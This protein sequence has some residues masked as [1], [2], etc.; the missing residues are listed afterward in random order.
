MELGATV[1]VPRDPRCPLCPVKRECGARARGIEKTLPVVAPK[2]KPTLERRAAAVL[3]RGDTV[4]LGRRRADGR[5]GGMWEPPSVV[6]TDRPSA[7][8]RLA[9]ALGIRL[10][11]LTPRGVVIHV[12]SHRRLEVD[13]FH[14]ALSARFR[15]PGVVLERAGDYE[16]FAIVSLDQL[17]ARGVTTLARKLL[18]AAAV[19]P[20]GP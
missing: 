6:S 15:A 2:K 8:A 3:T 7:P 13:V 14:G 12:L 18:A 20:G 16:A 10:P 17:A 19:R 4:L 11:T 1:C 5:F 9:E